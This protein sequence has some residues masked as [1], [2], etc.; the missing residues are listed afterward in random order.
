MLYLVLGR[1]YNLFH[2]RRYRRVNLQKIHYI[3]AFA[4]CILKKARCGL[5]ALNI[6]KKACVR[7]E[8]SAEHLHLK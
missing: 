6:A 8:R 2:L 1:K 4:F 5:S 3:R 7:S